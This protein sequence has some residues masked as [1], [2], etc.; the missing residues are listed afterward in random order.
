MDKKEIPKIIYDSNKNNEQ[1]KNSN[2]FKPG[3]IKSSNDI[4]QNSNEDINKYQNNDSNQTNSNN[5]INNN[6]INEESNNN[7]IKDNLKT[8]KIPVIIV[9]I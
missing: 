2:E 5:N 9:K 1:P 7:N 8:K 4:P 3:E 6:N